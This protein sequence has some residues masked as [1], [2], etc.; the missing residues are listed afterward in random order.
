MD[1]HADGS[2]FLV[3]SGSDCKLGFGGSV[4][5]G[6]EL[7][8]TVSCMQRTQAHAH[9]RTR[10]YT[11]SYPH[12]LRHTHVHTPTLCK[13]A[14]VRNHEMHVEMDCYVI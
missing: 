5:S 7:K 14:G 11:R 3:G 6:R 1:S 2:F 10:R 12:T 8:E 9:T 4:L 13:K